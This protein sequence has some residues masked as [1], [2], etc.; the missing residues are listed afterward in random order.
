MKKLTILAVCTA[1]FGCSTSSE[2]HLSQQALLK[3]ISNKQAPVLIDVRSSA[4]YNSGHIQGALHI[5]F[6][7]AFSPDELKKYSDD[8]RLVL[9]CE[10]GPRAGLAKAALKLSGFENI[11]YLEGHISAWKKAKLPIEK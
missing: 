3:R 9:Y 6:W 4:E 5:P 8:E 2:T 11:V 7:S 10:H 1:L